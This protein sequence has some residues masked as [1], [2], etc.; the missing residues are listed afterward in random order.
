MLDSILT[1]ATIIALSVTAG[2]EEDDGGFL[3]IHR[4]TTDSSYRRG[5]SRARMCAGH[6]T[7]WMLR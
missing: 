2:P 7:G 5:T 6:A 3:V 1:G 4:D